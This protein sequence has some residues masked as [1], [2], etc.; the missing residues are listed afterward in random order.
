MRKI[1]TGRAGSQI[2]LTMNNCFMRPRAH[3]KIWNMQEF[4]RTEKHERVSGDVAGT[5]SVLCVTNTAQRTID[6]D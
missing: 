2:Y 3:I 5:S 6:L 4:W 1:E